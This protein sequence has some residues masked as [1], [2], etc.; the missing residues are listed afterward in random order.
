M[1][2]EEI[3]K[4]IIQEIK[5]RLKADGNVVVEIGDETIP[6]GGVANFDSYN[7]VE[8]TVAIKDK[9]K[10]SFDDIVTIFQNKD[11][12]PLSMNNIVDNLAGMLSTRGG[13]NE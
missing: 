4:I 6:I 8:V 13:K 11:G 2:K 12:I 1:K 3:R 5:K 9:L 7:G 10:C